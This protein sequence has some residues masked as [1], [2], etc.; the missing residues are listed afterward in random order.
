MARGIILVYKSFCSSR[1]IQLCKFNCVKILKSYNPYALIQRQDIFGCSIRL[2]RAIMVENQLNIYIA[3]KSI[4]FCR[5][6]CFGILNKKKLAPGKNPLM[7]HDDVIKMEGKYIE[8]FQ[9]LTQWIKLVKIWLSDVK[10]KNKTVFLMN[11]GPY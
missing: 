2:V 9:L 4:K 6:V 3:D 7:T 5:Y 1:G 8:Y 10:S 11:I